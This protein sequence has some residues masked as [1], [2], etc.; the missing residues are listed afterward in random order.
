M[1]SN[2]SYEALS[3][4]NP[5]REPHRTPQQRFADI[6]E[7]LRWNF[8]H[9]A[10]PAI[11]ALHEAIAAMEAQS[12]ERLRET[13]RAAKLDRQRERNATE[14]LEQTARDWV[15]SEA[16][17]EAWHLAV[18]TI[19]TAVGAHNGLSAEE[20]C[21]AVRDRFRMRDAWATF[22]ST[23]LDYHHGS[24]ESDRAWEEFVTQ[25]KPLEKPATP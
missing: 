14:Q 9:S 2:E 15:A 10:E 3:M 4:G 6:E 21:V 12:L 1:P 25:N 18:E 5:H 11:V 8:G 19:C 23:W 20:A 13:E 22:L 17:A 16:R 24:G 7:G